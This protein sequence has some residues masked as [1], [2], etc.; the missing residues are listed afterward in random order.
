MS[1]YFTNENELETESK[2]SLV[3]RKPQ[4]GKTSICIKYITDNLSS[5]I[6]HIVLT[7]N[8]LASGMQFFGRMK[9]QI[10]ANRIVVFN[11][12]KKTAGDCHH[13]KDVTGVKSLIKNNNI[14][15][16]VCCA[17][18]KKIRESLIELIEEVSDSVKFREKNI[19]LIIH[20]DEAHKYI[21]ENRKYITDYNNSSAVTEIIGYS[22]TADGIWSQ[23]RDDYLFYNILIRDVDAQLGLMRSPHY[24]G[25][26]QCELIAYDVYNNDDLINLAEISNEISQTTLEISGSTS[27]NTTWFDTRSCFN[28]GNE[29]LFL[30]FIKYI[31]PILNISNDAFSYNFMPAYNRKVTHYE[32]MELILKQYSNANVIIMNGKGQQLYRF[33]QSTGRSYKITD[34]VKILQNAHLEPSVQE[35]QKQLNAL[36]EPSYMIQQLIK[37]T[38]NCPTFITGFTCVGMSVT[39]I[40]ENIGNFDNVVMD[41]QHFKRDILYQLCRFLFKYEYG[42]LKIKIK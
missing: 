22:A 19:K 35:K 28:H 40:N 5:N 4:E 18:N 42:H 15:V 34:N 21:P 17:H 16:I 2:L 10:G 8:T 20:I 24:F 27:S 41:H 38:P 14:K 1:Q 3:V 9:E 11:S 37:N 32:C 12:V 13:A 6:I 39:L 30:S 31:L 7:M 26:N 23:N 33:N 36:L 29:I 25:V